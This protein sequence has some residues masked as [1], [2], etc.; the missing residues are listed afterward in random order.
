ME[1][2][3]S[4]FF[5]SMLF[6]ASL[7]ISGCNKTDDLRP[8][9]ASS[10][11]MSGYDKVIDA[12]VVAGT[13]TGVSHT[14]S[15]RTLCD[16]NYGALGIGELEPVD[17]PA[18]SFSGTSQIHIVNESASQM[19]LFGVSV[20]GG[21]GCLFSKGPNSASGGPIYYIKANSPG[22]TRILSIRVK[23]IASIPAPPAA[24]C[25][26]FRYDQA[27]NTWTAQP[28]ASTYFQFSTNATIA[29]CPQK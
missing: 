23:G 27:T 13:W 17:L 7:V 21:A 12:V 18:C 6:G 9:T 10:E 5:G 2:V 8:R 19:R 15:V 26:W 11:M 29:V 4:L 14:F 28:G 22:A 1:T 24:G 16:A 25:G 3:K 20:M